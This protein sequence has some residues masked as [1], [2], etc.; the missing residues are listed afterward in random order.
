MPTA[1]VPLWALGG[2]GAKESGNFWSSTTATAHDAPNAICTKRE[3]SMNIKLAAIGMLG[4][5]RVNTR[6]ALT[7]LG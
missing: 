7:V 2:R 5:V 3:R 4:V 1:N 6:R